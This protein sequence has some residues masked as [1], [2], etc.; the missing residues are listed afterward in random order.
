MHTRRQSAAE[1]K[2]RT[3]LAANARHARKRRK[4]RALGLERVE[5]WLPPEVKAAWTARERISD[6]NAPLPHESYLDD[7]VEVLIEWSARWLRA[8]RSD[9]SN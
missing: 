6:A 3:R 8:S 5:L 4:L 7:L 1:A 2:R 9:A